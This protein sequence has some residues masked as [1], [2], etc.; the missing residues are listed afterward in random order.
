MIAFRY[1]KQYICWNCIEG[2]KDYEIKIIRSS[3]EYNKNSVDDMQSS[4]QTIN[5]SS[6]EVFY[7]HT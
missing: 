4:R 3:S 2:Y 5:H 7:K 1:N 6:V